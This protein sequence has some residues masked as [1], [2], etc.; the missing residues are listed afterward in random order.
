MRKTAVSIAVIFICIFMFTGCYT[1]N[2][3]EERISDRELQRVVTELEKNDEIKDNFKDISIEVKEN[4]II[5]KFTY[6]IYL[7]DLQVIAMKSA[8]LNA[9]F[10]TEIKDLKDKFEKRYKIRPSAI[11]FSFYTSDGRPIGKVEG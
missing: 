6:S 1:G 5:C 3:L 11:T 10:D 7:D 4:H 8:L 2:T 9:G